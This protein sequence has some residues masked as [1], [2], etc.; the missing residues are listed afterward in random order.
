MVNDREDEDAAVRG[1]ESAT[2][3]HGQRTREG[4][5]DDTA[6]QDAQRVSGSVRDSALGDEA[7]AHDVVDDAVA[8]LVGSPLLGAEGGG[9]GDGD[10]R[11]HAAH[12]DSGHDLIVAGGG[13][14]VPKT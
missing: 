2:K 13:A 14:A 11:H 9:E 5:T 8:A 4:C 6:G 3:G 1:A 10:G 7:E 12:H